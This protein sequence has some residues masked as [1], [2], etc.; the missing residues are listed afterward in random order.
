MDFS[1]FISKIAYSKEGEK[2]GEIIRIEGRTTANIIVEQPHAVIKVTRFLKQSDIILI[3][4]KSILSIEEKYVFFDIEKRK[5]EEMQQVYRLERKR[6][7]KADK[8][9]TEVKEDYNKATAGTLARGKG[10]W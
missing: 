2:L 5:F 3:P 7:L 10:L 4:L 9:K 6:K 8:A 1:E